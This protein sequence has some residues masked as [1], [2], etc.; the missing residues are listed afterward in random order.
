[1]PFILQEI[2]LLEDITSLPLTQTYKHVKQVK[3]YRWPHIALGRLVLSWN[4]VLS[5]TNDHNWVDKQ[6]VW[7]KK[8]EMMISYIHEYDIEKKRKILNTA[9]N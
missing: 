7:K 9:K 4:G 3:G 5:Y 8:K 2:I 1:M 6:V